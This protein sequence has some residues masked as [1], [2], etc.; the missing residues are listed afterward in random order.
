ME[1]DPARPGDHSYGI[2][3][4]ITLYWS[5]DYRSCEEFHLT[6][7]WYTILSFPTSHFATTDHSFGP[8]QTVSTNA[9]S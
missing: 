4:I 8:I 5:T 9:T 7:A 3:T 6:S 1:D 2:A